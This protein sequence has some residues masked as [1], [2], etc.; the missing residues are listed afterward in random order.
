MPLPSR[1][2][3]LPSVTQH[4]A[5]HVLGNPPV[6]FQTPPP[7]PPPKLA[8]ALQVKTDV[9]STWVTR[10]SLEISLF[11]RTMKLFLNRFKVGDDIACA[12]CGLSCVRPLLTPSNIGRAPLEEPRDM[13]RDSLEMFKG[14]CIEASTFHSVIP[15]KLIA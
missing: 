6:A 2:M 3:P 5:H 10:L 11:A 9:A 4:H 14:R 8:S 13:Q 12:L 1:A 7:L 15:F